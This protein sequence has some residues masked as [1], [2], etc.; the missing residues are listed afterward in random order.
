MQGGEAGAN[1]VVGEGAVAGGDEPGRSAG[2]RTFEGDRNE[3][4]GGEAPAVVHLRIAPAEEAEGGEENLHAL[5]GERC[6]G[7]AAHGGQL[8]FDL[9]GALGCE[10][11]RASLRRLRQLDRQRAGIDGEA[12][13]ERGGTRSGDAQ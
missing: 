2:R 11:Q 12:L 1:R 7:E 6:A 9:P 10:V 8:A 3:D 5:L 4:E 13:E